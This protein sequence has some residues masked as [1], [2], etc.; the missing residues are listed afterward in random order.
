M[1]CSAATYSPA[2]IL[3]VD[4]EEDIRNLF[5]LVLEQAGYTTITAP[6]GDTALSVLTTTPIDLLL[7]DYEMPEMR[8]DQLIAVIHA[9][10][11]SVKTIL[12]SGHPNIAQLA[13]ECGAD[14][15]YRK[16]EPPLHL[17]ACVAKVLEDTPPH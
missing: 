11:L 2:T 7:T 1:K 13:T 5:A 15:Y 16:G 10:R 17:L 6:S 3:V 9:Q 4:N 14:D 12:A 8:G